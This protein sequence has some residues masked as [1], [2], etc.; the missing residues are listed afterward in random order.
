VRAIAAAPSS[1]PTGL[2]AG[3]FGTEGF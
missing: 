1:V 3:T 2:G